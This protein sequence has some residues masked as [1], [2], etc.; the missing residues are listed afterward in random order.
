MMSKDFRGPAAKRFNW[1]HI[2]DRHCDNGMIA[3]QSGAKTV[4][5]GLTEVQIRARVKAA[6]RKRKR[7]KSQIDPLGVERILYRGTA[8][9]NHEVVEFWYNMNTRTV[10]TAYPVGA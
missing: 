5:A 10:E 1:Q 8:T 9:R 3:Q 4:F 7:I 2:F 6:W